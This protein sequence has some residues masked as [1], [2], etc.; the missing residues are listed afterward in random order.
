MG[1][2]DRREVVEAWMADISFPTEKP[3]ALVTIDDRAI[4]FT[5]MWPSLDELRAFQPWNKRSDA[6]RQ[7][8][9]RLGGCGSVLAE[10][11]AFGDPK[12]HIRMASPDRSTT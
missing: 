11:D 8:T 10:V 6:D 2:S 3:P 12:K 9:P 5:V 7:I 1:G 4:Q